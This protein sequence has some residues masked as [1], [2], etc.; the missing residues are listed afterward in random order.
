M[1]NMQILTMLNMRMVVLFLIIKY[2]S[3]V[4]S[5]DSSKN[6]E[7]KKLQIPLR[8]LSSDGDKLIVSMTLSSIIMEIA[9]RDF[10][11]TRT[12]TK[13]AMVVLDADLCAVLELLNKADIETR[14]IEMSVN[15]MPVNWCFWRGLWR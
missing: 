13:I 4:S 10:D 7:N 5:I 11:I 14:K 1:E 8:P 3:Y 15:I 9:C 12:I 6:V 2:V